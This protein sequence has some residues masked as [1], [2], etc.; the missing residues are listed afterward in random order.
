MQTQIRPIAFAALRTA[1]LVALAVAL[2]LVLL[3]AAL[4]VQ[5]SS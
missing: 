3:P 4:E 2:I 5:A 1:L